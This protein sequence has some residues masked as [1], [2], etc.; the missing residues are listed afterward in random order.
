MFLLAVAAPACSGRNASQTNETEMTEEIERV[1]SRHREAWMAVPGVVGTGIGLCDDTPCLKVFVTE[2]TAE[3][4]ER[5][6]R[7]V[8]RYEVRLEVTGGFRSQAD[9]AE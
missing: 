7:A 4:R 3:I 5:I 8:K 6:P 2:Q 9:T 1:L